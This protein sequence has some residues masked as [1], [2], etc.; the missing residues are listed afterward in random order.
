M[1]GMN[2]EER[3]YRV[4][5][6]G[7]EDATE[8]K[9][10][11]FCKKISE[12]YSIS[13][14]LLKKIVDNCPIA[15]KKNLS[16]NKAEELGKTL[17]SF[18]AIVSV[19]EKKENPPIFL[20]FKD[21]A[22][23]RV[24][25]E[26]SDLRRIPSGEWN[27]VGRAKNISEESLNDT[28]ILIQ[29]FNDFEELLT[30]EEVPIPFNPIPPG[31]AF[32]FKV[33]FEGDLSIKKVSIAFKNAS[34]YLIPAVD[35][36]KKREWVG[37]E[38]RNEIEK[39]SQFIDR[40]VPSEEFFIKGSSDLWKVNTPSSEP[41]SPPLLLEESKGIEEEA[42]EQGLKEVISLSLEESPKENI[43]ESMEEST[44]FTSVIPR[45]DEYQAE[46]ELRAPLESEPSQTVTPHFM[47][48]GNKED[49]NLGKV[50]T[51][52]SEPE[53]PP[54]LLE[55]SKGIE[56][57]AGEQGSK[58]VISLSLEESPKENIPETME[59]ST[60]FTS[61]IP[62]EDEY[63][64]EEELR[65]P[66]ES[67]PSQTV[68][69]HSVENGSKED[70]NL[71]AE[72]SLDDRKDII[73]ETHLD[74]PLLEGPPPLLK[75]ISS[76]TMQGE[77]EP[78]P[79]IKEFRNSVEI[80]YRKHRDIFSTWYE[81]YQREDGLADPLHSLLTILVHARFNQ[82]DFSEKTLENTQRVVHC[83]AQSNLRLEEIP[84]L[85][86]TPFF[87]GEDWRDLF[88]KAFPKLQQVAN[89]ILKKEKWDAIDLERLIG[90]V[91]HMSDKNSR[92][93][94]RWM[95]EL[96]QDIIEIDFSN[97]LIN[98]GENLYRVASRLGVVD[99]HFDYYQG[100]NSIGDL[101]IQSF[102]KIAFPQYPIK[103]EEPMTWVGRKEEEG[104]YC[105]PIQPRC[106]GCLFETF[107]PK[108]YF[109]LN[110][111]GKGMKAR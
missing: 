60:D 91:P 66:L 45:E 24:A 72:P 52:S 63:Q 17:K 74:T 50:N 32:P 107:C 4:V 96:I 55:E 98:I 83:I 80:Y 8:E 104:G 22:P 16:R 57:E 20:E 109:H 108:L 85:E 2:Q 48:N 73:Q 56:E 103:I 13:L 14:P 67:E 79:W 6:I 93:S 105:F 39:E 5:L 69:L 36:R 61:V 42:G 84:P 41:E 49:M 77:K 46:E 21:K 81:T 38:L 82:A 97:T 25:L 59:E 47:E 28:W 90:V 101:K 71:G 34:G 99:P 11:S 7:I 9:K 26:S 102:A 111:S 31:E 30:F 100:K 64:A 58:E 95:H 23:H 44:D 29:T 68:T 10:E 54:L 94:T 51:P 12:N 15:L 18:G 106:E 86:G 70:M 65:V 76:K 87:S 37:I 88:H 33:V 62:R 53:S 110:P 35:R 75:E 27:I 1:Q 40:I 92:M 43:P 3:N 89:N 19:E 78:F